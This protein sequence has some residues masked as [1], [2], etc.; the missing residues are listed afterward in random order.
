MGTDGTLG[1]GKRERSDRDIRHQGRREGDQTEHPQEGQ[2]QGEAVMEGKDKAREDASRRQTDDGTDRPMEWECTKPSSPL[3][4]G[5]STEPAAFLRPHGLLSP[6]TQHTGT[7]SAPALLLGPPTPSCWHTHLLTSWVHGHLLPC[8]PALLTLLS[9]GGHDIADKD[10][11]TGAS[12]LQGDGVHP[13]MLEHIKDGLEPQVLDPAL[14]FL[15][16]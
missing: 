8:R 15:I 9:L 7:S 13:E 2:A 5:S 12:R 6:E 16:Q 11:V 14:T 10:N 3:P 1:V 4:P